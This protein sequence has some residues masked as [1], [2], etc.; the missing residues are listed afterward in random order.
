MKMMCK[1]PYIK[2]PV[3]VKPQSVVLSSQARQAAT[4]FPC[5][6]CMPCR[7]NRS[8]VWQHRIELEMLDHPW[9]SFVT[10]TYNDECMPKDGSLKLT[11]LQGFI[12]RLRNYVLPRRIRYTQSGNMEIVLS[13]LIIISLC[14]VYMLLKATWLNAVGLQKDLYRLHPCQNIL[15]L[16]SQDTLLKVLQSQTILQGKDSETD[17]PSL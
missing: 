14:L 9:S 13:V 1:D 12:K 16:T 6:Q 5:G 17:S 2:T 3:G 4:P 10:L 8:R 15:L 11:D 7:I